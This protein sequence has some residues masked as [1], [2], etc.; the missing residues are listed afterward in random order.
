MRCKGHWRAILHRTWLRQYLKIKERGWNKI[1]A[2]YPWSHNQHLHLWTRWTIQMYA[3]LA[4]WFVH[5]IFHL[6]QWLKYLILGEICVLGMIAGLATGMLSPAVDQLAQEFGISPQVATYHSLAQGLVGAIIPLVV[7]PFAN[8]YGHRLIFLVCTALT[9]IVSAASAQ[10]TSFAMLI[11]LRG[12][13]GLSLTNSVLGMGVI[14]CLF[15]VH[16]RGR[17]MGLYVLISFSGTHLAP[18]VRSKLNVTFP[19][20]GWWW[21]VDWRVYSI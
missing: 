3:I 17:M 11:V 10:S 20:Y 9:A 15:F 13:T 12:L 5:R 8:V 21:I 18:A 1:G 2:V 16:Q 7:V 19:L 14:P 4:I 6:T